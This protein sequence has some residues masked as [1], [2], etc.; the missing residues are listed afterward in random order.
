MP[1]E[2]AVLV[3][4]TGLTIAQVFTNILQLIHQKL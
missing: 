2:D 1:A 3:D 4:T